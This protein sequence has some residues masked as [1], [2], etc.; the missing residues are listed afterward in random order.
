MKRL[1]KILECKKGSRCN[2]P[3]S[4]RNCGENWRRGKFKQ[5]VNCYDTLPT[6]IITY[7]VIKSSNFNTLDK[8][9]TDIYNLIEDIREL[10]KRCKIADF[11]L[12]I[13]VSFGKKSLGFNPHINIL[14]FGDVGNIVELASKYNL[15][16]WKKS[17]LNNEQV[18]KSIVWYML[19]YNNLGIEKGEAVRIA[20][21][22]RTTLLH[23][24][25]FNHKTISYIDDY[26]DLDFTWMG[27]YPIRSKEEILFRNKIKN[28]RAILS[29][30][31]RDFIKNDTF[32]L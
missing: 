32:L 9:I 28:D 20:L 21:N 5:F 10:K 23:S 27:V 11:Y 31:L 8:G 24:K 14:F 1:K 2:S 3:L 22:K 26:I 30:S 16:V 13:E 29:K 15:T 17:K 4:C 12:K 7:L 6:D 18:V 25:R 19:K